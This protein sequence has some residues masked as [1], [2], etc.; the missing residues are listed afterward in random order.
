MMETSGKLR[1]LIWRQNCVGTFKPTD[2]YAP[3]QVPQQ[4]HDR[5]RHWLDEETNYIALGI[6]AALE[7]RDAELSRPMM[8]L[9]GTT[10]DVPVLDPVPTVI[11]NYQFA[12]VLGDADLPDPLLG[13]ITVPRDGL[14][15]GI[16]FMYGLQPSLDK[17][18]EIHLLVDIEAVT[19]Y[20][21]ATFDVAT[22][23]TQARVFTGSLTGPLLE[24]MVLKLMMSATSDMGAFLTQRST[25]QLEW[26]KE[27]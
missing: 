15:T 26:I 20:P 9:H 24:G 14:Y 7:H 10:N 25:F 22:N 2:R 27:L 13:T 5:V 18:D 17:D 11:K 21:V 3:T 8:F 1:A 23:K 12:D 6:N 16:A 4:L 19:Q